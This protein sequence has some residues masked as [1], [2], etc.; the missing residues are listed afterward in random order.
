MAVGQTHSD[1]GVCTHRLYYYYRFDHSVSHS[2]PASDCFHSPVFHPS[3]GTQWRASIFWRFYRDTATLALRASIFQ[4]FYSDPATLGYSVEGFHFPAILSRHCHPWVLSGG[5]LFSGDFIETLPPLHWGLLFSSDF[6][7]TLPP[8]GTQWRASIFRRFYRD[9]ST[10]AL[11]ASIL[12]RFYWDT[13]TLG[14]S[15]EG[16][17]FT[18][19]LSR[20]CHPCTEGFYFPVILSRHCNAHTASALSRSHPS[21]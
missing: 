12:Q 20:H 6:I 1:G 3:L 17:Y 14:Y 16:F 19:I 4:Q 15:V 18:A 21:T 11:R 2:L 9:T 8:L 13:A 5:L 7:Q 10:L